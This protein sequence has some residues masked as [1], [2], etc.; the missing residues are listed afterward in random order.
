[1]SH[2][3]AKNPLNMY[4]RYHQYRFIQSSNIPVIQI[5]QDLPEPN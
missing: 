2:R 5:L 4:K 3:K 1:M